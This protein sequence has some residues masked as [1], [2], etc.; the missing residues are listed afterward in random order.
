[1]AARTVVRNQGSRAAPNV[2]CSSRNASGVWV[3]AIAMAASAGVA[4]AEHF[5][6]VGSELGQQAKKECSGVSAHLLD[7][8]NDIDPDGKFLVGQE[9]KQMNE[10]AMAVKF[11]ALDEGQSTRAA[12][13]SSGIG[14]SAPDWFKLDVPHA[15]Q[16][17]LL[18]LIFKGGECLGE[19]IL[20]PAL[21]VRLCRIFEKSREGR[22]EIRD[23]AGQMVV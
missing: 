19:R 23:E 14:G 15:R 6:G 9:R 22:S 13:C 17:E 8:S 20:G 3:W 11:A 21:R 7:G 4:G 1:M 10:E 12:E 18:F 5:W 16:E 2:F